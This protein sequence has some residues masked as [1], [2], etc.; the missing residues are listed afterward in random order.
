MGIERERESGTGCGRPGE[1]GQCWELNPIQVMAL[2]VRKNTAHKESSR[3]KSHVHRAKFNGRT[4]LPDWLGK[5]GAA[6]SLGEQWL[7]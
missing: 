5:G 6:P 4:K 7:L 3:E 2:N 1:Q